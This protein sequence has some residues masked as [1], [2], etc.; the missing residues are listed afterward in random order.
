MFIIRHYAKIIT[1]PISN[2]T[3]TDVLTCHDEFSIFDITSILQ[4]SMIYGN[5][6]VHTTVLTGD[7][8]APAK[9]VR[10]ACYSVSDT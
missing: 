7:G 2:R 9:N 3:E 1:L 6:N 8:T 10:T 4:R 5:E